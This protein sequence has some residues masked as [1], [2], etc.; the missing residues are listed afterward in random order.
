[1]VKKIVG[2]D[3]SGKKLFEREARD[4]DKGIM[5]QVIP[6]LTIGD[7]FKGV[8]L[9]FGIGVAYVNFNNQFAQQQNTNMQM[10]ETLKKITDQVEKHSRI[11][12]HLDSYLS[13]STGRQFTD[14][15]PNR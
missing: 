7:I 11:L 15:E 3:E 2:Y 1:M 13:S 14:G 9:V 6:G 5:S 8:V 12:A 10:I 4:Y